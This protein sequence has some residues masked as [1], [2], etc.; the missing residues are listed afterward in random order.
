MRSRTC[1]GIALGALC[2]AGASL[3]A[4]DAAPASDSL[5]QLPANPV[6]EPVPA[7]QPPAAP[8]KICRSLDV[9]GSKIPKR[10]C[11]TPEEWA[12]F[13]NRAHEDAQDG[14]RH[15][16]DQGAVMPASPGVSP[17]GR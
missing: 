17:S 11:A 1:L 3:A 7:A 10:V 8:K 15:F 4:D 16:Q 14:I 5:A 9:L 13:S 12:S 2:V 6:T